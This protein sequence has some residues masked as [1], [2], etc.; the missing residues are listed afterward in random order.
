MQ[1]RRP[2]T[3]KDKQIKLCLKKTNAWHS[4][5]PKKRHHRADNTSAR[6]SEMSKDPPDDKQGEGTQ[7]EGTEYAE[8]T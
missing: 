8:L 2:S 3:A 4:V 1:Q 6:L 7:A 5:S